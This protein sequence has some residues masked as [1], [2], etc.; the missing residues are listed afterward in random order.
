M[1]VDGEYGS[2]SL[3]DLADINAERADL[4]DKMFE[5]LDT[6]GDEEFKLDE[7]KEFCGYG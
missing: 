2:I 1:D 3:N 4:L 5:W 7:F 6:N